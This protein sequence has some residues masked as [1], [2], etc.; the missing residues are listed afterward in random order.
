MTLDFVSG[1]TWEFD[2][3][4]EDAEGQPFRLGEGDRLWFRAKKNYSDQKCAVCAEQDSEH[5]KIPPEKTAIAAGQYYADIGIT[6]SNGDI[7]T[8]L[9]EITLL[10]RPKVICDGT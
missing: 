4:L 10:I 3:R 7:H 5:F 2:I 6:F 8:L 9:P 1:D